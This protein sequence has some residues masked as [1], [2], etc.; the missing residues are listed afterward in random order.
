MYDDLFLIAQPYNNLLN[1]LD[2]PIQKVN[3]K[4]MTNIQT[5]IVI[6]TIKKKEWL[7]KK[8]YFLK[9]RNIRIQQERE[10]CEKGLQTGITT[11]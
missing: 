2:P 5:L 3:N 10:L 7:R 9:K 6:F 1:P 8:K 11:S 4:L